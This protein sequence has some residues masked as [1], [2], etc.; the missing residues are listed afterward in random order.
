MRRKPLNLMLCI[1]WC[2]SS[3]K[4]S[5]RLILSECVV[6]GLKELARPAGDHRVLTCLQAMR[7]QAGDFIR[8]SLA[9]CR[10]HCNAG[11]PWWRHAGRRRSTS[12]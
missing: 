11:A 3:L 4:R 8:V 12:T 9:S 1:S 7:F 5:V 2:A 10:R 6:Y